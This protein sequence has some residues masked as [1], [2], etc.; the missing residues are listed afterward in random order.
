M[1]HPVRSSLCF[2]IGLWVALAIFDPLVDVALASDAQAEL[3]ARANAHRR[4]EHLIELRSS[5]ELVRIAQL[6]ADDM[7]KRG[8]LA[9]VSPEGLDPLQRARAGGLDGFRLLAENI[10]ASDVAG[11]RNQAIFEGWLASHDHRANLENPAFN[12][13]GI[14]IARDARGRSIA[15]QLFATY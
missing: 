2:A 5:P 3:L 6:H 12:T 4:A 9:H 10:G 14:A 1:I 8:Y 11:S 7:A 15:V 13:T